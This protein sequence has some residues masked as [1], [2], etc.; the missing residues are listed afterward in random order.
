MSCASTRT[1]MNGPT[2]ASQQSGG[3]VQ[4]HMINFM[5]PAPRE[6]QHAQIEQRHAKNGITQLDAL[7][8]QEANKT[9]KNLRTKNNQLH[10]EIAQ[11]RA[12]NMTKMHNLQTKMSDLQFENQ[13][14]QSKMELMQLKMN[15]SSTLGL[16]ANNLRRQI[17][18]QPPFG[19]DPML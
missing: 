9:I 1:P 5:D 13:S 19:I 15:M 10:S 8:L 12:S 14:L 17:H 3:S 11:M 4:D 2:R 18:S 7:Q 16:G 6:R